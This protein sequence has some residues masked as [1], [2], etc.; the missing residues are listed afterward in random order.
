MESKDNRGSL[1]RR[2][3]VPAR[4]QWY[5]SMYVCW[6]KG[7]YMYSFVLFIYLEDK[8]KAV[9]ACTDRMC[10]IYAYMVSGVVVFLFLSF[11][12]FLSV[13]LS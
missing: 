1:F 4:L 6:F 13:L 11:S 5:A 7:F 2:V 12:V 8:P 3:N 9:H 10:V